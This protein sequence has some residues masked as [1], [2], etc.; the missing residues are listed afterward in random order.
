VPKVRC[1]GV[2]LSGGPD[3]AML[4]VHAADY[5]RRHGIT[6]HCLHVHHGLQEAAEQWR[7]QAFDLATRLRAGWHERR[8]VV[9]FSR[10]DGTE[11]AARTARYEALI[12]MSRERSLD[13]VLLA[14]HQNDQ[15]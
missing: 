2:G 10:G 6:L 4:A 12:A 3:S 9:D 1:L 11:S 5:A 13:A 8:V 7:D 14:H 15:A